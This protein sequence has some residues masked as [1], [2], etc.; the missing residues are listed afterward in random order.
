MPTTRGLEVGSGAIV[1]EPLAV[2]WVWIADGPASAAGLAG[3]G[4]T[5]MVAAA[6]RTTPGAERTSLRARGVGVAA[7]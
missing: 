2:R 1:R 3:I 5:V 6:G 4:V 7:G